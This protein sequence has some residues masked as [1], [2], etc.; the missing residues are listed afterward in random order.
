MN[1]AEAKTVLRALV[2]DDSLDIHELVE[3]F[4]GM[5]R[6]QWEITRAHSGIETIERFNPSFDFILLD[7]MMP[8]R[9]GLDTG[10]AL[11]NKSFTGPMVIWSSAGVIVPF[12]EAEAVAIRV[13]DKG[14]VEKLIEIIR[15]IARQARQ[16]DLVKHPR[17][18]DRDD[19]L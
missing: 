4:L 10:R 1:A 9:N 7:Y 14:Q 6:D 5:E 17:K 16:A 15:D 12:D 19:G 2:A 3:A 11:R 18:R 8:G 13:L